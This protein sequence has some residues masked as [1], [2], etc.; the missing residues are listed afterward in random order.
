MCICSSAMSWS[1][2]SYQFINYIF[3]SL[4]P[5]QLHAGQNGGRR[6]FRRSRRW[7]EAIETAGNNFGRETRQAKQRTH[8][9]P[10][11]RKPQ[12][13]LGIPAHEGE[14][15]LLSKMSHLLFFFTRKSNFSSTKLHSVNSKLSRQRRKNIMWKI[16]IVW[17]ANNISFTLNLG[18]PS[19]I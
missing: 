5:L 17:P 14:F 19:E 9:G 2:K 11:D 4:S 8:E 10:Q 15:S 13:K 1:W 18:Y 6:P 7:H 12:Q 3:P 16:E